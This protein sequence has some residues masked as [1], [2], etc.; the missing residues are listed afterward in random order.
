MTGIIDVG[1]GMRGIYGSGVFDR[2]L[3]DGLSFDEV[4]GVSAGSANATSFLAGQRGRNY[5]FYMEYSFRKSYMSPDNFIKKGSFLDLEYI[6]GE[7]SDTGGE[8]PLDLEAFQKNKARLCIVATNALTGEACY[9]DNSD[10]KRDDYYPM[11]ASSCLPIVGKEF[12][13]N[14]VPYYDGGVADP[15]PVQKALD[16]GCD[17]VVLVLTKPRDLVRKPGRD[18]AAAKLLARRYPNAAKG[19]SDRARRYNEGVAL[20]KKLEGESRA[21]IISPDH[22]CGVDTLKRS[23][24]T[25]SAL[26]EKGWADAEKIDGFLK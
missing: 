24:E 14:G 22:C 17:K 9:F 20:A 23:K 12:F 25:L 3:D 26:Y 7:L 5:K 10:I 4:I 1:G 2:C 15:V 13:Y 19:L 8:Y 6:Y 11:K 16:D 21:L 18:Q